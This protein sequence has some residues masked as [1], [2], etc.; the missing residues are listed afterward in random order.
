MGLGTHIAHYTLVQYT[1]QHFIRSVEFVRLTGKPR[2]ICDYTRMCHCR[3]SA[4][5]RWKSFAELITVYSPK[6]IFVV[7]FRV[8]ELCHHCRLRVGCTHISH[9][10]FTQRYRIVL[11]QTNYRS[12]WLTVFL[13]R[14][15]SLRTNNAI[16]SPLARRY[17]R[18][19][20]IILTD[21]TRVVFDCMSEC[22]TTHGRSACISG[23]ERTFGTISNVN[24][25][26][27]ECA[28]L[29]VLLLQSAAARVDCIKSISYVTV[30]GRK[31][32]SIASNIF[33]WHF[34]SV[35]IPMD[36]ALARIQ[37]LMKRELCSAP[38][39]FWFRHSHAAHAPHLKRNSSLSLSSASSRCVCCRHT[40]AT[41]AQIM[42][43]RA[44]NFN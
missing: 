24:G 4:I 36:V 2:T 39:G 41:I 8:R 1:N 38:V 12:C 34:K 21:I 5:R 17:I 3:P 13:A 27:A 6:S 43:T 26:R 33:V 10:S 7:R 37:M 23:E 9:A 11:T 29:D 35:D 30:W 31:A 32:T 22:F 16:S 25:R 42:N 28:P 15:K 18:R 20:H 19:S 44:C 40:R 14:G